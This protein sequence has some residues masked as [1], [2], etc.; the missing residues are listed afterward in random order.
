[1]EAP[2]DDVPPRRGGRTKQIRIMVGFVLV[3]AAVI[4]LIARATRPN[5]VYYVTVS[6]LLSKGADSARPGLRV[7]G[8]VVPGTIDRKPSELHFRMTDGQNAVP[9][10]YRGVVPD[11]FGE[12][13]EVVV[14]GHYVAGSPF[15]ATFLMAKCPSKYQA[16]PG[17]APLKHP[18]G[19]PKIS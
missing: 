14:E 19:I 8:K 6:E 18:E 4:A 17:Q 10:T 7:A 12:N 1:M 2:F 11:T 9:V 5:M 13:G 15:E 16:A 3:I